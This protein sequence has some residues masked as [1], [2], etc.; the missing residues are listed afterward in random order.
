MNNP[1]TVL[2]KAGEAK[3][4]AELDELKS[5]R[6]REIAE[7]I[8]V[9]LSFGDMEFNEEMEYKIVGT[10]EADID[11]GKLSDESPIGAAIL[12]QKVGE[13]VDVETPGGTIQ[14][15]VLEIRKAEEE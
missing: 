13:I 5:V 8:K 12:G 4:K 14:V 1:M 11:H 9:A 2:T 6:R 3:L 10:N 15:K 7:K